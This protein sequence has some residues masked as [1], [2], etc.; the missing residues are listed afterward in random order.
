[1]GQE[2]PFF[3]I[4]VPT[5]NRP[6]Q[7]GACLES[8][9]SL[10]YPRD[11]F[12]VIVVD[13]GGAMPLDTVI[14]PF[15]RQLAVRLLWQPN[16]GPA[17]ARNIGASEAKGEV[18]VFM[19]DD[20]IASPDWLKVLGTYLEKAVHCAV[21]GQTLN[22]LPHN[23]CSTASQVLIAYLYSYYNSIPQ[24]AR[25]FAANNV[26]L[27]AE[28]FRAVGGFDTSYPLA[29]GEDRDFCDR[30][31]QLGYGMIYAPEAVV[32]HSHD[33]T[34]GTF[35]R[36]HFHYG[37]GAFCYRNLQARRAQGRIRVEPLLFYAKMLQYPF[38]QVRGMSAPL[39]AA[40]FVI[41][42]VANAGGFFWECTVGKRS[43]GFG[44]KTSGI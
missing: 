43:G 7:L 16:A 19:D 40:L 22:A 36:Q 29:A 30:W 21:G 23:T 3:S 26:A 28:Q 13:D 33:L 4:I 20:C 37:R 5:Y 41:A 24:H 38:V 42:Q 31:L 35:I 14:T 6:A 44:C 8:L 1:M 11:C 18:F 32:Y 39:I 2:K 12:E 10:D 17:A 9:V 15:H 34:L 25:F 27:P